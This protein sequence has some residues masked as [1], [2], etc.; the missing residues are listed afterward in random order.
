MADLTQIETSEL[1]D[2]L[3]QL[4]NQY[5]KMLSDGGTKHEF[6][7]CREMIISL[8]AEIMT[9][10]QQKPQNKDISPGNPYSNYSN[11]PGK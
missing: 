3:A 7:Q 1:Y 5:M 4:T 11:Q 8:Q 9:R 6:D 10:K 2:L